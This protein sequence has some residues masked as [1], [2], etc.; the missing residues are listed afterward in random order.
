[1]K[2]QKDND[3][4]LRDPQKRRVYD[5]YGLKGLENQ[6]GGDDSPFGDFDGRRDENESH[7]LQLFSRRRPGATATLGRDIRHSLKSFAPGHA[8]S[9]PLG[10]LLRSFVGRVVFQCEK[11][12]LHQ[13]KCDLYRLQRVGE[14][15]RGRCD[16]GVVLSE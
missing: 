9:H 7:L 10:V 16:D 4:V 13:S 15:L 8:I 12:A 11:V 3:D 2:R 14:V 5:Q 1:M 6:M